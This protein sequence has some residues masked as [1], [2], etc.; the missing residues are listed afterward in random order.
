MLEKEVRL[1][2]GKWGVRESIERCLR[3]VQ[4]RVTFHPK[5]NAFLRLHFARVM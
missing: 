2:G 3:D 5:A 4:L 1:S